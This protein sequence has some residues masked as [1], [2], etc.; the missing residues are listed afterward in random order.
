MSC[1]QHETP[2]AN[3][4]NLPL[5]RIFCHFSI[6]GFQFSACTISM[7]E[8]IAIPAG[9]SS[10]FGLLT[11]V[12]LAKAGFGPVV[13]LCDIAT[14]LQ[15]RCLGRLFDCYPVEQ[16][17]RELHPLSSSAFT[18]H[19]DADYL[20]AGFSW[21]GESGSNH[22]HCVRVATVGPISLYGRGGRQG[23]R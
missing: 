16:T 5:T 19:C 8:E 1:G 7:P 2:L 14:L 12:E 18:A 4:G 22:N 13:T 10:S 23:G 9:L 15:L 6:S 21:F 20:L 11:S 17:S 3:R